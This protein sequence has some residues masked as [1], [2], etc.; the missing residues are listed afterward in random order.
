MKRRRPVDLDAVRAA[1]ARLD[2]LAREHPELRGR[3]GP[4]NVE[5]WMR[6]LEPIEEETMKNE[7]TV[8]CAFRLPASLVAKL[9]DFAEQMGQEQPGVAFT[10]AD[11]VRA[12]LTH[13]LGSVEPRK[14]RRARR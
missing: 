11:A 3:R 4:E 6:T 8:Q 14:P 9:D 13:A 10:R 7:A 5:R 1:R 2:A 12:L